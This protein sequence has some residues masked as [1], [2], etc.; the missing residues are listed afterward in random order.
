VKRDRLDDALRS[1]RTAATS[2]G[3]GAW[4]TLR[5]GATG[6]ALGTR[7]LLRR[8]ERSGAVLAVGVARML[9][10]LPTDASLLLLART[11]S[12]GQT[13]AGIETV[14]RPLDA[15]ERAILH[16]VFAAGIDPEPVRVKQGALGVLGLPGRAFVVGDTIHA[17]MRRIG[18][19]A[20]H[21]SRVLVHELVHVWQHQHHGTR[22]LSECLLAQWF[23]EGYNVACALAANRPWSA[24]NFEQ[25]AEL[26]ERAWSARWFDEGRNERARLLVRLTDPRRDDGFDVELTD[27]DDRGGLLDGGWIDATPV[28]VEGLETMRA[29]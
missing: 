3:R 7:G 19:L 26:V 12:A 28:L 4:R 15:A 2:G 24:L 10:Q 9:L 17:P 8:D 22:Y 11:V 21:S 25:Q 20:D 27:A 23:G 14:G 29:E 5:R 1:L 18:S 6:V 13:L 16:T